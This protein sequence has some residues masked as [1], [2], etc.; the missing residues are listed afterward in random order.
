[1]FLISIYSFNINVTCYIV[2]L[3]KV[4]LQASNRSTYGPTGFIN[5]GLKVEPK[6]NVTQAIDPTNPTT[7]LQSEIFGNQVCYI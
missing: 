1:M 5:G 6:R 7:H 2:V 3:G 4:E